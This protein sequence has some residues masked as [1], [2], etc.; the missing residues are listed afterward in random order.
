MASGDD[1]SLLWDASEDPTLSEQTLTNLV[2]ARYEAAGKP[3]SDLALWGMYT[4]AGGACAHAVCPHRVPC[5]TGCSA[6]VRPPQTLA[7]PGYG[8]PCLYPRAEPL[9]CV[10]CA[11]VSDVVVAL[12]PYAK[13]DAMG[14]LYAESVMDKFSEEAVSGARMRPHIFC[15]A[16]KAFHDIRNK[17]QAI[18]INGESGAGKTETTKILI[19]YLIHVSSRA[20]GSDGTA[21]RRVADMLVHSSPVLEAFGN[22]K[23]IRNDNSSRFGK[24]VRLLM[25]PDG[26]LTGATVEKYLLEKSRV[27]A[28]SEGERSYHAFYHLLHGAPDLAKKC[29]LDSTGAY[30]YLTPAGGATA[31]PIDAAEWK[32]GFAEVDAGLRSLLAAKGAADL[33]AKV[34]FYWKLIAG[35]LNLGQIAFE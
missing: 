35:V 8:R 26:G 11:V 6:A 33:E 3:T 2:R 20:G 1:V 5:Y 22:A 19:N 29:K 23:T 34:Q 27:V 13:K 17:N 18:V 14:P 30:R 28:H 7:V 10:P 15:V 12:N 31:P 4:F 32:S 9:L 24:Y 25:S 16:A 21:G